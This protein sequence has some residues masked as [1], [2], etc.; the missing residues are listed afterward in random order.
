[1]SMVTGLVIYSMPWITVVNDF[2][3]MLEQFSIVSKVNVMFAVVLLSLAPRLVKK[4]RVTFSANH[5]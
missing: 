2:L 3:S 4:A 1:M 5:M